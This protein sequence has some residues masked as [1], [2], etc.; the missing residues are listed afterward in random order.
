MISVSK[1]PLTSQD[2]VEVVDYPQA[3]SLDLIYR[4]LSTG[5]AKPTI[6]ALKEFDLRVPFVP[7]Q[8]ENP[9]RTISH[10]RFSD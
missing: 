4:Y 3:E 5:Q 10:V 9:S 7:Q 8:K 1:T 6:E 2:I